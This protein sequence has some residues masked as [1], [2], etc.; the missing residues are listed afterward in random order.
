MG[1]HPIKFF[2]LN[3]N[4]LTYEVLI[5]GEEPAS[6]V[7]ELR[8]QINKLT[9]LIPTD[10]ICKSGIEPEEDI[11]GLH[12]SFVEL[13]SQVKL[14]EEKYDPNIFERT[15]ALYNHLYH[16]IKRIDCSDSKYAEKVK[17]ASKNLLSLMNKLNAIQKPSHSNFEPV[18]ETA[19]TSLIP[20]TS[21]NA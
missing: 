17:H 4:E 20:E 1:T 2:L 5:R 10:D 16:R 6:T 21:F 15:R 18:A 11:A 8:K 13:T 7:L 19:Q 9:P 12:I 3:K 14:L